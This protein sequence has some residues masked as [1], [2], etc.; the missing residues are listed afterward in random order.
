[1]MTATFRCTN[2]TH[3][4]QFTVDRRTDPC[5]ASLDCRLKLAESDENISF[6]IALASHWSEVGQPS[7]AMGFPRTWVRRISGWPLQP[8]C[9]F[10]R[11][12]ES[13]FTN[14]NIL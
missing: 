14:D 3:Y 4:S 10:L 9:H 2:K 1:M 5:N 13:P 12:L 7:A 6:L 8:E 11:H